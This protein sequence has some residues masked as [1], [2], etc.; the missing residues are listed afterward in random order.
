MQF[1]NH[2]QNFF[3]KQTL[4]NLNFWV[5]GQIF[6]GKWVYSSKEFD[7]TLKQSSPGELQIKLSFYLP[8]LEI[9]VVDE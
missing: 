4:E 3:T 6:N 5:L 1:E 8:N 2:S 7:L 9:A